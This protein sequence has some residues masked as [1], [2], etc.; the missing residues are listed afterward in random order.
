MEAMVWTSY[1]PPEALQLREIEK[2]VPKANELLIR[3]H[4]ATVTMGD[5]EARAFKFPLLFWVPLRLYLGILRPRLTT[6][7]QELAGEIAAVGNAV[8]QFKPGDQVFAATLFRFCAYAEYACLPENYPVLLKPANMTF[9]E[10]A[11]IPTGGV[12]GL[13]FIR[14]ANV[15]AGER[16]LINGAGGSIGTYALQLARARGA[17]VTGVDS[18]EKLEMLAALGA[19]QVIDYARE[20][21]TA[22]D[23]AYDVII[24]VVGKSSFSACIRALRPKGRYVLGNPRL[25]GMIRG[26]W[27][28]KTTGTRVIS[29]MADYPIA[30]L[31]YL[32]EQI[33]AGKLKAVIDRAFPLAA[34]AEAHRYVEQGH[35]KGNVVIAIV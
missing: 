16:V 11:T 30:D 21:F 32:K 22:R 27:T 26:W 23:A 6:L 12:N 14:S 19:D 20:D 34:T 10:A 15:Q 28:S 9:A 1:G 5:C 8:T 25:A 35:K 29:K 2:P 3:V 4:A 17:E 31:A 18:A 7:G 24:D 13:H 33:E